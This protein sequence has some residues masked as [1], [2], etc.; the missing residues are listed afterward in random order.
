MHNL[1]C[2]PL[3][4]W[5]KDTLPCTKDPYWRQVAIAHAET[6]CRDLPVSTSICEYR[7]AVDRWSLQASER[8][9]Q[10]IALL[11]AHLKIAEYGVGL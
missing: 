1:D 11:Q 4:L 9:K 3:V 8:G 7:A 6:I 2:H 10:E 5:T